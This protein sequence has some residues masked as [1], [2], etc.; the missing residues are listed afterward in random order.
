[1]LLNINTG[2]CWCHEER[3]GGLAETYMP[4][5]FRL[6]GDVVLRARMPCVDADANITCPGWYALGG[7]AQVLH[8]IDERLSRAPLLILRSCAA[9][10]KISLLLPGPPGFQSPGSY[11]DP[12]QP[13]LPCRENGGHFHDPTIL[14]GTEGIITRTL[15]TC[16]WEMMFPGC[17]VHT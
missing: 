6:L 7:D 8:G 15:P 2:S 3:I 11:Q 10:L 4:V 12:P 1:M 16:I 14:K 13:V 17:I 9:I 5:S